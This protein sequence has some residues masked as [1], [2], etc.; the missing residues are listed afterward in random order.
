MVPLI[1]GGSFDANTADWVRGMHTRAVTTTDLRRHS[2]LA[3]IHTHTHTHNATRRSLAVHRPSQ[4]RSLAVSQCIAFAFKAVAAHSFCRSALAWVG[5]CC[6]RAPWMHWGGECARRHR[7]VPVKVLRHERARQGSSLRRSNAPP[8]QRW[9]AAGIPDFFGCFA[10]FA[11][12]PCDAGSARA[13]ANKRMSAWAPTSAG[14][15][16]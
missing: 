14:R 1:V 9:L 16:W 2:A 8:R 12:V 13:S 11:R 3:C 6:Y 4:S 15:R 7:C 10:G 5:E